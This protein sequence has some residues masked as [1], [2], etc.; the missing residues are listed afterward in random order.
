ML[1]QPSGS[2]FAAAAAGPANPYPIALVAFHSHLLAHDRNATVGIAWRDDDCPLA[3][4]LKEHYPGSVFV[5]NQTDYRRVM[6]DIALG[7]EPDAVFPLPSWARAFTFLV[8]RTAGVD[9]H[10]PL[11]AYDALMLLYE[12]CSADDLLELMEVA[13][14]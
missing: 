2:S 4:F 6:D 3:R 13:H 5:V 9:D 7:L 8:D 11:F 10:F 1:N 12:S 14:V